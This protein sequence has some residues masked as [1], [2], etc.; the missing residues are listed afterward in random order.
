T[1]PRVNHTEHG[2]KLYDLSQ[3]VFKTELAKKDANLTDNLFVQL[4]TP[5]EISLK[6]QRIKIENLGFEIIDY[7]KS[8]KSIGT[9]TIN[10]DNLKNYEIRLQEYIES[11]DNSGKTYFAPIE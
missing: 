6:S 8:N 1:V 4:E 7:S 9:A 3:Q 5:T 10:K 2:K 11:V